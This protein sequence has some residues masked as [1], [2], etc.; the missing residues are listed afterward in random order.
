MFILT[1]A[2][3]YGPFNH[4]HNVHVVELLRLPQRQAL[5]RP[6]SNGYHLTAP[7]SPGDILLCACAGP[8]RGLH[9]ID[10]WKWS[11]VTCRLY[12][13]LRYLPVY[14]EDNSLCL[15]AGERLVAVAWP[16]TF[17]WW[18]SGPIVRKQIAGRC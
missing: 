6:L 3:R 18:S 5:P 14:L 4:P 12:V 8:I 2:F 11:E 16:T 15:I 9:A 17:K 1:V 7:T 13:F 10:V